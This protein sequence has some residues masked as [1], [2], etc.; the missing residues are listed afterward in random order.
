MVTVY[1]K[2]ELA[3]AI[4]NKTTKILCKGDVANEITKE[5]LNK[6]NKNRL[7][8]I[9]GLA[10]IAAGTVALPFTGGMSA[11]G[12]AAGAGIAAIAARTGI[13][14][15]AARAGLK[16]GPIEMSPTELAIICGTI[17]AVTAILRDAKVTFKPDGSVI[18]E[19]KYKN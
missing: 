3:K 7:G 13:A 14:A 10:M 2:E 11:A 16:L 18:V 9:A 17:I 19:P 12:I 6:R 15:I 1:T 8:T 4:E 5:F